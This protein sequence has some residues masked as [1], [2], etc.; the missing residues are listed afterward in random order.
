M[1]VDYGMSIGFSSN[2]LIVALLITQFVGFPSTLV[3]GKLGQ[4]WSVRK[5]IFIAIGIYIFIT[6]WGAMMTSQQE[7]YILAIIVGLVQ[8]GIQALSR[9]YYSRLIPKNQAAEYYGFYNMVGKFATILGPVLMG[10]VGL[11]ARRILM[12]PSPT[13]EQIVHVGQLASRWGITSISLLF[14]IGAM[15]FFFVDEEKGRIEAVYLSKI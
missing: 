11:I 6:I 9:S 7:F 2:D 4:R 14:I 15:L 5:S 3:F 10:I 13:P 12:P 8:G 1:A